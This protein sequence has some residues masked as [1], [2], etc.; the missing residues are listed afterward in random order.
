MWIKSLKV[1]MR[2]IYGTGLKSIKNSKGL[3]YHIFLIKH[4]F[5][6]V[7]VTSVDEKMKKKLKKMN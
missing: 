1:R 4:Y 7:I 2:K 6:L 3:K 5:V